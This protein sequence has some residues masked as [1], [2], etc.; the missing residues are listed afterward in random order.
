MKLS[1]LIITF[2]HERYIAQALD[3]VL[4]QQTSFD[5]EIVIGDD[6]STDGTRAIISEYQK[7]Y[8]EKIR[9]L[10]AEKNLG[11]T[12]NFIK[13]YKACKGQYVALLEGDDFWTS[14]VK[15]QK[16]ADF[17]DAHERFVLCFTNSSVV[18]EDGKVTKESRL[19]EDRKRDLAQKDIVS[20]LVPPTNTVVF[21][22]NV[23]NG[24][25]D[26]FYTASNGDILF[27]SM[28]TEYGDAGYI[29]EAAGA[30]RVHGGGNWAAKSDA[31]LLTN[32]LKV[33][34]A[35][36]GCLPKYKSILLPLIN[37]YF[38][39]LLVCHIRSRSPVKFLSIALQFV[40]TDI[41]FLDFGF[42]KFP[43][44]LR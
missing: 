12:R 19:E 22:N 24:I 25:P 28:L 40:S 37:Q 42:L 16:Q 44:S 1:V 38:T 14:G 8:P 7:R 26:V 21:R 33:R 27:F 23:V 3:S 2:N 10:P 29:D 32:N 11:P 9:L 39:E 30:Y 5:F 17:L 15:L 13:T 6:C 35:L 34:L 43:F 4:S 18:N 36:L 31:Y 20:G 41:K